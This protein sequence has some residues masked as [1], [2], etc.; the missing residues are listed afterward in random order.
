MIYQIIYLYKAHGSNA[1]LQHAIRTYLSS[2]H[3]I[4]CVCDTV[5]VSVRVDVNQRPGLACC[6]MGGAGGDVDF[7]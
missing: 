6:Q 5:T 2:K 4:K 3:E 7:L 1:E